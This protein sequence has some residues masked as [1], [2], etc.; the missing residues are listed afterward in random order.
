MGLTQFLAAL[1]LCPAKSTRKR[2]AHI[3]T[4]PSTPTRLVLE[5]AF[6]RKKAGSIEYIKP[7]TYSICFIGRIGLT[8]KGRIIVQYA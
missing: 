8:K 5:V 7:G 1:S 6:P 4:R 3:Q 2:R